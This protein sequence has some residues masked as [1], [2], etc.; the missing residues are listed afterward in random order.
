VRELVADVPPDHE[1]H[2][3]LGNGLELG[4]SGT[5]GTAALGWVRGHAG[6]RLDDLG[7][8]FGPPEYRHLT[9]S[10]LVGVEFQVRALSTAILKSRLGLRLGFSFST[11]DKLGFGACPTD[12]QALKPCSNPVIEGYYAAALIGRVRGQFGVVV[13][14]GLLP[15]T[16]TRVLLTPGLGVE[17]EWP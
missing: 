14:P 5:R 17:Y 8:L 10:L 13:L 11:A 4:Y 2:A 12:T 1:L 9:L 7:S 15:G 3:T 16:T 6:V